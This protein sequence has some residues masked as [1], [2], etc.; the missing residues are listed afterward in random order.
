MLARSPL[1][2]VLRGQYRKQPAAGSH[3]QER[4]QYVA[5]I[6]HEPIAGLLDEF[7]TDQPDSG[8]AATIPEPPAQLRVSIPRPLICPDTEQDKGDGNGGSKVGQHANEGVAKVAKIDVFVADPMCG[9]KQCQ[10]G[11]ACKAIACRQLHGR[12]LQGRGELC[13]QWLEE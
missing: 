13:Q 6:K 3:T 11:Q 10:A 8:N 7:P 12:F 1:C 5:E 9:R 4:C 2:P